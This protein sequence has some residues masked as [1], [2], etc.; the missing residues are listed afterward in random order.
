[1]ENDIDGRGWPLPPK[2]WLYSRTLMPGSRSRRN[3]PWRSAH[4]ILRLVRRASGVIG[5]GGSADVLDP[6]SGGP[7]A[8]PGARADGC[9]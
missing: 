6:L 2:P 8:R 3:E 1:M 7:V 9:P 5:Q 4:Q